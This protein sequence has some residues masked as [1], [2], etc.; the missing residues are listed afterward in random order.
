MSE[1]LVRLEAPVEA[2]STFAWPQREAA[3]SRTRRQWRWATLRGAVD[4]TLLITAA[5]LTS[6]VAG[7]RGDLWTVAMLGAMLLGY[8]AAGLYRSRLQL[9][10]Q[11]ELRGMVTSN[12]VVV[13]SL[14]VIG[15]V[16]FGRE[17]IGDS[18]VVHW[19]L[20]SGLVGT[21]R[22][23][24]YAL[25][26][27]AM[28]RADAAHRTL[29]IGAGRVGHLVAKRLTDDPRLG[30]NPVGFLDKDP[31][32]ASRRGTDSA[33]PVLGASWDL[34]QVIAEHDI[35]Q[36]IVAFS[37]APHHVLLDI[38]RRCWG[39][40]V[41]VMVVPRLYEVDG[42]RTQVEHLGAL[43]LVGV[44][45]TD[46]RGWQFTL[47][48]ALDRILATA[49]LLALAP[50]IAS[51][52]LC[53]LVT[54]GRPVLFRQRRVGRDG[55]SF[56]M[57]KFRT[58][59]GAPEV[60][61]EADG[62]WAALVLGGATVD[63]D[64]IL[65]SPPHEDRRTALGSLLRKLSLDEL[66]QLWNVLR[67][68]MSLIGPRPERSHYVERFEQAVYRYPDRHR[69]KSGLTGWAQVHGLRGETSLEDRI[70]WDNF[71]IENW[72]PGLDLKI[73]VRTLPALIGK[74]GGG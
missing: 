4:S 65:A 18:A 54:M 64:E 22:V 41:G 46:P 19:F 74:R 49:A 11:A 25:E 27:A 12:A 36:V 67:G 43:P 3:L 16:I 13:V 33:L 6:S 38:V 29:I 55:H 73:L 44:R 68:D 17:G 50:I 20:A 42:R 61:G 34:E 63:P 39:Q 60:L 8:S 56:E 28:R 26:R 47:K 70:E 31:I 32:A 45:A 51:I 72:S 69:V 71:Y 14:S 5:A 23:G 10:L 37:T 30:L 7:P 66:P 15:L 62:R 40:S 57:L 9:G 24:L 21:G 2:H 53:I 58:M 59:R 1:Q 52:A 48:Y 35:D